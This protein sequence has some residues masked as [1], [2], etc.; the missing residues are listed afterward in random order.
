MKYLKGY[1]EHL[2]KGARSLYESGKLADFI[3]GKYPEVHMYK[4]DKAL[5]SY[6][7]DIKK[8]YMKKSAPISKIVYDTKISVEKSALGLH[9]FHSKPHGRKMKATSEIRISSAF[10]SV[11]EQF[12]RMIVVH[13]LAHLK[14]KEHNK[15]F[16]KLC[17][18]MEPD[19]HQY[20]FDLRLYLSYVDYEG[21]LY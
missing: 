21:A 11:P 19:Y 10:R 12:L 9:T 16:Y 20:E 4:N 5:A 7:Q 8:S 6:V 3:L 13:E 1:P 14:E 17:T 18:H 15:A 2:L